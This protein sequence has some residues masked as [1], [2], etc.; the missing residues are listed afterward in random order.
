MITWKDEE[1]RTSYKEAIDT[2][3][4]PRWEARLTHAN[5]GDYN[6]WWVHD[7]IEDRQAEGYEL[8]SIWAKAAVEAM[9][10][11]WGYA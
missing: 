2:G 7:L 8:D 3:N 1:E 6:E 9:L 10:K 5:E 4:P 11:L